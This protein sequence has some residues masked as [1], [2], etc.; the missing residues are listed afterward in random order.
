MDSMN[1]LEAYHD[2]GLI[3]ILKT[4]TLDAEFNTA[5]L[6]KEKAKNY[7]MIGGTGPAFMGDDHMADAMP[8][9]VVGE[10]EFYKYYLEIFGPELGEKFCRRS[11]RD[12]MH[13]DQAILNNA[14]YFITNEK[15]LIQAGQQV[16]AIHEKIRILNPEDCLTELKD[17]LVTNH[18]TSKIE[19]LKNN[20]KSCGPVMIGSNSSFGFTITDPVMK[21]I[22]L[23]SYIKDGQLMIEANIRDVT[24][25]L[26]LEIKE[27]EKMKF[28]FDGV[29]VHCL[30]GGPLNLGEK[31]FGQVTIGDND[32]IYLSARSLSSNRVLFDTVNLFSSDGKRKIIVDKEMLELQGLNIGAPKSAL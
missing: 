24:G 3:E 9:A 15:R 13:I 29:G 19:T 16:D 1:E 27:G 32:T 26:I 4:S 17:Y 28:H 25:K 30:G 8:G 12:C 18:G 23:S 21:E 10:S 11:I 20:L 2:A 6:Q 22:L 31:S 7:K 5:P 14:N